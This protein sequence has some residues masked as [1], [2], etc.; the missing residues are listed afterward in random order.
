MG[1]SRTGRGER[2]NI[3]YIGRKKLHRKENAERKAER[4]DLYGS[5]EGEKIRRKFHTVSK[6]SDGRKT[7]QEGTL[8]EDR[9]YRNLRKHRQSLSWEKQIIQMFLGKQ[10]G[11]LKKATTNS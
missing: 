9:R 8:G 11:M 6:L 2:E 7:N 4:R 10:R 1:G 5:E 3:L